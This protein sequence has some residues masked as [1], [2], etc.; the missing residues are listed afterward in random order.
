EAGTFS[1]YERQVVVNT[2]QVND[3]RMQLTAKAAGETVEVTDTA[4]LVQAETS[5]IT[6][7][8]SSTQANNIPVANGGD[9]RNLAIYPP[10]VTAQ[11]GG[12]AGQ[13]GSVGGL[14]A[15]SN[16]F[17]IDGLDDNDVSTTGGTSG[18]IQ[19]AVQE[20][21][22]LTNNFSAEYG[23]AGGGV[24]NIVSKSGTN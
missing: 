18:V 20:F 9:G 17:N 12:T 2:N 13:G 11:S 3:V 8:F 14:R 19:D 4:G 23:N 16:S 15:R 21:T 7:T 5:Q 22:V 1:A 6:N 10:G 24:F